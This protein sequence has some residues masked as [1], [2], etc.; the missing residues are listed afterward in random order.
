MFN[1]KNT[2]FIDMILLITTVIFVFELLFDGPRL[3]FFLFLYGAAIY[4]GRKR[5]DKSWGRLVFWAGLLGLIIIILNTVAFKFLLLTIVAYFVLKWYHSKKDPVYY[6]PQFEE[7]GS[8]RGTI[9][10]PA[11]F[12]NKWFGRQ[13]TSSGAY[14]WQDVNIQTGIGDSIIDMNN[15]V[16]PKG[17]SVILIRN[18]FGNIEIQVPYEVEITIIHS[19][20]FGSAEILDYKEKQMWN[21][22][23]HLE[24]ENYQHAKQKVKIVTSMLAGKI[25]VKRV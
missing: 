22:V 1:R 11:M 25:E 13:K 14:E 2:D 19:A 8:A 15:T 17:E 20:L 16:L 5:I 3:L 12:T 23:I 9:Q 10:R 4:Y 24:T 18:L 21:K 7:D 6:Q